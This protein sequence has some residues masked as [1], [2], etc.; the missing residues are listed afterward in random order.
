M[1]EQELTNVYGGFFVRL[2]AYLIDSVIIWAGLL[3]IKLPIWFSTIIAS[4]N[5]IVRPVLF[6]FS[7]SDIIIYFLTIT[8]FILLTYFTGATPGKKLFHLQ[9]VAQD[10]TRPSFFN[11][12]YRESIGRYLAGVIIC[13][14]YFM[15]GIDQQKR[16]LHDWLCDTRVIYNCKMKKTI[17]NNQN[18]G[19]AVPYYNNIEELKEQNPIYSQ[20]QETKKENVSINKIEDLEQKENIDDLED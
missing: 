2:A 7:I 4:N 17:Y 11:I 5:P 12:L 19:Y 3:I 9:V 10:G 20:T 16:G 6:H 18:Q 13:I 1:Q 8:Y 15:I 14:G